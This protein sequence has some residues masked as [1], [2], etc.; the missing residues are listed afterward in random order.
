MRPQFAR[1][2]R[3][4]ASKAMLTFRF[5]IAVACPCGTPKRKPGNSEEQ[6]PSYR[7]QAFDALDV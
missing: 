6:A 2:L 5:H 3:Q 1:V 4:G 7:V